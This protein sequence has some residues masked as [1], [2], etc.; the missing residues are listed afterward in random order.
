MNVISD[1]TVKI[2]SLKTVHQQQRHAGVSVSSIA[3]TL[4]P[5]AHR[6]CDVTKPRYFVGNFLSTTHGLMDEKILGRESL[7]EAK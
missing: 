2:K 3:G 7:R 6:R 5:M 4:L 1:A